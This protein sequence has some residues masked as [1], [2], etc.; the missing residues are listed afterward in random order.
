VSAGIGHELR[1]PLTAMLGSSRL[2]E[3]SRLD[4]ARIA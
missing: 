4:P 1:S 2:V 3:P